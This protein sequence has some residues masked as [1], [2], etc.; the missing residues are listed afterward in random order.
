MN[1]HDA[2]R[3]A[4]ER[5]PRSGAVHFFAK[6]RSALGFRVVCATCEAPKGPAESR[7]RAVERMHAQSADPCSCGA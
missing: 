3:T 5:L 1:T 4:P 2:H 7:A 6:E